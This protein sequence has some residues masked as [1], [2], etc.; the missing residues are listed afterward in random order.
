LALAVAGYAWIATA[1]LLLLVAVALLGWRRW[2]RWPARLWEVLGALAGTALGIFYS[3]RGAEFRVWNPAQSVREK[4][5]G[6]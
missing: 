5:G 2:G 3:L 6:S 1:S 4:A